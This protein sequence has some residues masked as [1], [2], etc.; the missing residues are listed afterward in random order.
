MTWHR[1]AFLLLIGCNSTDPC[2]QVR[3]LS[4]SPDGLTLVQEEHPLGWGRTDCFEC[5]QIFNIHHTACIGIDGVDVSAINAQ[6]DVRDTSTCV[7]CHGTNGVAD[8]DGLLDT[9]EAP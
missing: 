3:D 9:A 6:I 7:A 8:W 5:H 2:N 4:R 1:L